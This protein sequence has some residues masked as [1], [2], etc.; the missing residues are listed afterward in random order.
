MA[1]QQGEFR[2]GFVAVV[3]KPNV[4]KSTLVN[5]VVGQKVSIV[6]DKAQTTRKR[7]LGI[8]TTGARQIVFVDT[9]G[10]HQ[11]HHRL[12][13]VLNE[14]ARQS[15]DGVDAVLIMVNVSRMPSKED[16]HLAQMLTESG[17]LGTKVKTILC[18]N[19]MDQL[20]AA[21]VERCYKAYTELFPTTQEMMTSLT[22]LENVEQLEAMVEATLPVGPL[23][24][25]DDQVTDQS[26]RFLSGEIVREKALHKTFKEVPHAVAT[27]VENWEESKGLANITVVI[28]VE[29]DSQKGILIGKKGAMLKEIGTRARTE[30]EE[31]LGKKVFLELFVRVRDNWRSSDRLLRELELLG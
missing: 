13:K 7:V 16:R 31:L 30:I 22:K 17:V 2:S 19:K 8:S 24:F 26:V 12:G 4:G 5:H 23:L 29:R 18:M 9:P 6:S 28:L 3:G 27:Y 21:D 25:P 1:D 20:R 14:T 10:I 11:P 15:M